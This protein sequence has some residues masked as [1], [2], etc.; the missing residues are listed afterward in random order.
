M[1]TLHLPVHARG[2]SKE[3][4]TQF[5]IRMNI[6]HPRTGRKAMLYALIDSGCSRTTVDIDWVKKMNWPVIK[7][8]KPIV[9][10][11]ADGRESDGESGASVTPLRVTVRGKSVHLYTVVGRLGSNPMYLGLDWLRK[12]NPRID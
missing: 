10:I 1:N 7:L 3:D 5:T 9:V 4:E 8:Q 11:Y 2:V 6:E 12:A